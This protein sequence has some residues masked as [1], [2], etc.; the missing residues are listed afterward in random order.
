LWYP[1][2][3]RDDRMGPKTPIIGIRTPENTYAIPVKSVAQNNDVVERTIDG[4]V[5]RFQ[6]D[7]NTQS[8]HLIE[9]PQDSQMILSYWF[10]WVA[11]H[12]NTQLID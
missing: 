7:P 10:A 4:Q 11:F 12:P 9:S 6:L 5:F 8:V 3:H 2:A 1:V